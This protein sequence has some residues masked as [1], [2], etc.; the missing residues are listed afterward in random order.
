MSLIFAPLHYINDLSQVLGQSMIMSMTTAEPMY[1][2]REIKDYFL[3]NWFYYPA[4]RVQYVIALLRSKSVLMLPM[5][6]APLTYTEKVLIEM[7]NLDGGISMNE[8]TENELQLL[9]PRE[10]RSDPRAQLIF[11][12]TRRTLCESTRTWAV[13]CGY[14]WT[15]IV[16]FSIFLLF[17]LLVTWTPPSNVGLYFKDTYEARIH[18]FSISYSET[19]IAT[20][21]AARVRLGIKV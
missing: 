11:K 13:V 12:K 16:F 3:K 5:S 14:I 4:S 21:K 20:V 19:D 9:K 6:P 2:L 8:P 10:V 18:L 7:R 1:T 15:G 17:A